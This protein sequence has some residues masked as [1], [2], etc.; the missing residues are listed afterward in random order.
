VNSFVGAFHD[1]VILYAIALNESLAA[2]VSISNG[3]EI[4]R[5]MWN[6]TFTGITGTVSIDDNGDRNADYSLLDMDPKTSIFKV[7]ANYFGNIKKYQPV[8]NVSIH[9]A[10]GRNEAPPDTPECGFDG[11]KCPP[12]EPF[13][14][15][16]I[17][18]IVLGAVII[19]VLIIAFFVYRH[20][21]LE[22]ELAEMNWRV[23]WEDILF[24]SPGKNKKLERQGSRLSL[25]RK[26]SYNSSC[27]GDTIAAHLNDGNRQLYTKTGY[28]KGAIVAI[29]PVDRG[30]ATI[31]KP[32]LLEIKR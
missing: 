5:R 19:A 11:S 14:L 28:Y 3:S 6:R 10:G 18:I 30:C 31:H 23:R 25:N 9:W 16:V 7:V 20:I 32:L 29:K 15:Y 12:E 21:R 17:V 24:G 27:S 22:A 2:N 26:G 13:P 8:D 4:T 1:A